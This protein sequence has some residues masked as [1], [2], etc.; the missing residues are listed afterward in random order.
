MPGPSGL[1][2][3]IGLPGL[4]VRVKKRGCSFLLGKRKQRRAT[5]K[6]L[7]P[8][9]LSISGASDPYP[10]VRCLGVTEHP[11]GLQQQAGG[12]LGICPHCCLE[13]LA[14]AAAC[15]ACVAKSA[16]TPSLLAAWHRSS[17]P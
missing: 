5:H 1:P 7:F 11:S 16:E 4:T 6:G 15:R 2:G 17:F 14:L 8:K 9:V 10:L 12:Q 13:V 3:P